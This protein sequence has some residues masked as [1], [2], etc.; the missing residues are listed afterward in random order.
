MTFGPKV[1]ALY[2]ALISKTIIIS[3]SVIPWVSTLPLFAPSG[4]F[5]RLVTPHRIPGKRC[6]SGVGRLLK[7]LGGA[8]PTPIMRTEIISNSLRPESRRRS[9][10]LISALRPII[11]IASIIDLAEKITKISISAK[12]LLYNQLK[13]KIITI[14][15]R[16]SHDSWLKLKKIFT[17]S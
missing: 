4:D 8:T 11:F 15:S 6:Q 14:F 16:L 2:K 9:S 17:S 5:P 10:S 12:F 7:V 13:S 1:C 3:A